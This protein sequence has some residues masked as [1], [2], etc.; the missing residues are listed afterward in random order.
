MSSTSSNEGMP[1]EP[2]G[3]HSKSLGMHSSGDEDDAKGYD[4]TDAYQYIPG[5]LYDNGSAQQAKAGLGEPLRVKDE[6]YGAAFPPGG[7]VQAAWRF[8]AVDSSRGLYPGV[9]TGY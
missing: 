1:I 6:A 2:Y 7:V 4:A 9:T 5:P 3:D 8:R